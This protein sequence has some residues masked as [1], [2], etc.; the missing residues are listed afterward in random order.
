MNKKMLQI[1]KHP[2]T[3]PVVVGIGAALAGFG[4]G[5]RVAKTRVAKGM[6]KAADELAEKI[7]PIVKAIDENQLKLDIDEAMAPKFPTPE[8][9]MTYNLD[10]VEE[11]KKFHC[12]TDS[13]PEDFTV[14]RGDLVDVNVFE[15]IPGWD[16]HKELESRGSDA[17]YVIHRDEFYGDETPWDNQQHLTW[18]AGDDTMTNDADNP[19]YNWSG[20]IGELNFGH[21]SGD[22]DVFYVRNPRLR[23]EYEVTRVPGS[24][25][26]DV[27]GSDIE[28]RLGANELKHSNRPGKF[29]ME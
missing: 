29:R 22:P 6:M 23:A 28:E 25:S 11:L 2:A 24:Y 7:E 19:V 12:V 16:W 20:I 27:L 21:G 18:W 4:I 5:Y 15:Q 8:P 17:P 9:V 13:E 1:A 26:V 3:I 10:N 14:T